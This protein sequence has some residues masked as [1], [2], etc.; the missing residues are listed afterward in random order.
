MAAVETA[1]LWKVFRGL[2]EPKRAALQRIA[3]ALEQPTFHN[4]RSSIRTENRRMESRP[5]YLPGFRASLTGSDGRN[6]RRFAH[7]LTGRVRHSF[8]WRVSGAFSYC[9]TENLVLVAKPTASGRATR[10]ASSDP[11]CIRAQPTTPM[12][13][14]RIEPGGT[15]VRDANRSR[16]HGGLPFRRQRP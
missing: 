13:I 2:D 4:Y 14:A 6:R 5:A 10:R 16:N 7:G 8:H 3:V 12:G 11:A 15:S 9:G 1:A